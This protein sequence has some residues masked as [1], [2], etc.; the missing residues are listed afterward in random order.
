MN[1]GSGVSRGDRN[2][3]ARLV[4]LRA[5]VPV[6]TAVVGIDLA[7][8][9]QM[10]VVANHDS[11]VLARR[12]FRCKAWDLGAALDWAAE[13]AAALGFTGVTV[14]V[15]RAAACSCQRGSLLA[16]RWGWWGASTWGASG[17]VGCGSGGGWRGCGWAGRC[18]LG[19]GGR[20]RRGRRSGATSGTP[21]YV[22]NGWST[23]A[24]FLRSGATPSAKPPHPRHCS[25]L[26]NTPRSD[27]PQAPHQDRPLRAPR[28]LRRGPRPLGLP[29]LRRP[30]TAP[31]VTTTAGDY[32]HKDRLMPLLRWVVA[33]PEEVVA[34]VRKRG[35]SG[36]ARDYL[37]DLVRDRV[38]NA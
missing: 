37:T 6:S 15:R 11:V 26:R 9:K 24:Q 12:T 8:K 21:W 3:N 30:R 27:R 25:S 32:V 16:G 31:P 2:R 19:R 36:Y 35:G 5:A 34:A 33:T 29:V 7:E 14:P 23:N 22:E 28:P 1:H 18:L 38:F 20:V 10:V 4:R 17:G 13:R